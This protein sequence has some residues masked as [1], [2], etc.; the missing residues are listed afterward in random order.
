[1][2]Y[3]GVMVFRARLACLSMFSLFYA[4]DMYRYFSTAA[5]LT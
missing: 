2:R 4:K 3:A 1:M 5:G